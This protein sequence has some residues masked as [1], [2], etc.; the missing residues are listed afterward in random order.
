M[1]VSQPLVPLVDEFASRLF[2]EL[3]YVQE[4]HNCERFN[5]CPDSALSCLSE[6]LCLC[7]D[8]PFASFFW[9][10]EKS[11]QLL[12]VVYPVSVFW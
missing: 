1:Q 4:G 12:K 2:S 6:V 5:V 11:V 9:H 10:E 3:D 8:R 7:G